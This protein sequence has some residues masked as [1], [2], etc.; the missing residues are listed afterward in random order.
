VAAGSAEGAV[1]I[2]VRDN[3]IGI[4]VPNAVG[5]LAVSA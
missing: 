3:R 5:E 1:W 2:E 4:R